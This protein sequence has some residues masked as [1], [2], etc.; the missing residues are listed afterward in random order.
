M[1]TERDV[2]WA[3]GQVVARLN[4]RYKSLSRAIADTAAAERALAMGKAVGDRPL[5]YKNPS[6]EQEGKRR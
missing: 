3:N 6:V 1:A 4:L 5:A 2:I